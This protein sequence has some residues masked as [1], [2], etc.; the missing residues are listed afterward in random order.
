MRSILILVYGATVTASTNKYQN[1]LDKDKTI[2]FLKAFEKRTK[3]ISK[4]ING[5]ADLTK[6]VNYLEKNTNIRCVI[7]ARSVAF[8][9]GKSSSAVKLDGYTG[10]PAETLPPNL[11][12]N[13]MFNDTTFPQPMTKYGK[14]FY[15][16]CYM[17]LSFPDR[18]HTESDKTEAAEINQTAGID[19]QLQEMVKQFG[20]CRIQIGKKLYVEVNGI[21]R[22]P[23]RMKADAIF[24]MDG[25]DML[26]MSLKAG[27]KAADF[28][29][30]GG[31]SDDL[32]IRT[33][34]ETTFP[35]IKKFLDDVA[36]VTTMAGVG[37]D[38]T[39][40]PAGS[41][42]AAPLTDKNAAGIVMFGK[43]F[44]SSTF[45][46]NNCHVL[47]DGEVSFKKIEQNVVTLEADYGVKWHPSLGSDLKSDP[48]YDP[49]L[50][51]YKSAALNQAGFKG[52]RGSVWPSNKTALRYV[53]QLQDAKKFVKA[54]DRAGLR[55][56]LGMTK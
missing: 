34:A 2:A 7:F 53:K 49:I 55:K 8:K 44:K 33:G 42:F 43:D 14:L 3:H 32:G 1:E 45:G 36:S 21:R 5:N 25:K 20:S 16:A 13:G 31:L 30:Y 38:L 6:I 40:M 4:T 48:I 39:K 52:A 18:V 10:R 50:L 24:T 37:K 47:L 56:F 41:N 54:G 26:F 17:M 23:G 11:T 35:S 15:A 9:I 29:Q 19:K 27:Q 12:T 22:P 28:Q 51:V 46:L